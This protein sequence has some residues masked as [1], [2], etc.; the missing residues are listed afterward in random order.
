MITIVIAAGTIGA[1]VTGAA[2][3]D[4]YF[5]PSA[6]RPD[7]DRTLWLDRVEGVDPR[8]GDATRWP[9]P[10]GSVDLFTR[11]LPGVEAVSATALLPFVWGRE[12]WR[13]SPVEARTVDQEFWRFA[14]FPL[15][16]GRRPRP[17]ARP[18][19]P[20]EAA[21]TPFARKRLFGAGP[22]LG[23]TITVAGEAATVVGI[24]APPPF[25]SVPLSS[26]ILVAARPDE[27]A[28]PGYPSLLVLAASRA[29]IPTVQEALRSRVRS[30]GAELASLP[31]LGG[32]ASP[33]RL[34]VDPRTI[35]ERHVQELAEL[36]DLRW[37]RASFAA[38]LVATS[39]LF[40]TL[41][42]L[43]LVYITNARLEDRIREVGVRR[44][45]GASGS[46]IVGQLVLES[47]VTTTF[48]AVCALPLLL[49]L[50]S[51]HPEITPFL[52]FLEPR[53]SFF[54]YAALFTVAFG[55]LAGIVPALRLARLDPVVALRR[56]R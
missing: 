44:A 26:E 55:A 19:M 37:P 1:L 16:E 35:P 4:R 6:W 23:R 15:L 36:L 20:L 50:P 47:V 42:A 18:G 9:L 40:M 29:A 22:A 56:G 2:V 27:I 30:R 45:F 53:L 17:R 34:R 24:V 48:G 7:L 11:D 38:L 33:D 46:G 13:T 5:R 32:R 49:A 28:D 39:L 10:R 52:E 54:A 14:R 8:S 21:V 41:P 51:L 12:G 3:L 31:P 43:G 25:W